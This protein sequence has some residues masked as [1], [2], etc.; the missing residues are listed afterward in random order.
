[1]HN[2]NAIRIFVTL[3]VGLLA[4]CVY[5]RGNL[6]MRIRLATQL[7]LYAISTCM[8]VLASPFGQG[9]MILHNCDD[10]SLFT[11]VYRLERPHT[12]QFITS[13]LRIRT[14]IASRKQ[15][16]NMQGSIL[17]MLCLSFSETFNVPI[18]LQPYECV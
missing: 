6:S 18:T 7:S 8:Q 9:L 17:L 16:V 4:T 13:D 12:D 3:E 5:L 2:L 11:F 15:N 1:M 14:A 10:N